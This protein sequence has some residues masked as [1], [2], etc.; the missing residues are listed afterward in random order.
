MKTRIMK[1]MWS[2]VNIAM[3]DGWAPANVE[4]GER[5]RLKTEKAMERLGIQSVHL[6]TAQGTVKCTEVGLDSDFRDLMMRCRK[7]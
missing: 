4:D 2:A 5:Q 7:R 6:W 3:Q 1:I